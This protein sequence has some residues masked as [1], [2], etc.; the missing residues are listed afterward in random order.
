MVGHT[1]SDF[2][3]AIE[4]HLFDHG[5]R[6]G[7]PAEYDVALGPDPVQQVGTKDPRGPVLGPATAPSPPG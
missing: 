2:E 7:S 4:A 5:W 6:H 3:A 1:E